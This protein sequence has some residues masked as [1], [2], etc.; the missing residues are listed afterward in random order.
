MEQA[1]FV[2]LSSSFF[3]ALFRNLAHEVV[4]Q[5]AN[6]L[7]ARTAVVDNFSPEVCR[8]RNGRLKSCD[9][10]KGSI[11]QDLKLMTE[12]PHPLLEGHP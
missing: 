9:P 3:Q 7:A 6:Q 2:D 12:P 11:L 1:D 8:T 5:D 10:S 4:A